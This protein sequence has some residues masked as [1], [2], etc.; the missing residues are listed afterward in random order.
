[1]VHEGFLKIF[2][3][4]IAMEYR[5]INNEGIEEHKDKGKFGF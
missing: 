3:L 5:K 2:D 4:G 1:M